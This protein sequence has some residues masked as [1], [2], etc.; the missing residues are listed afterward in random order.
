MIPPLLERGN[1]EATSILALGSQ[2]FIVFVALF[3]NVANLMFLLHYKDIKNQ[4]VVVHSK[5]H[6]H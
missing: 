3:V 5:S 1:T 2:L 6:M 4:Q